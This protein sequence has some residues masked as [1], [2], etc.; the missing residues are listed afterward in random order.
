[1]NPEFY[2][3][4]TILVTG[5]T[6]LIGA[7]LIAEFLQHEICVRA[8]VHQKEPVIR[9]ER[10]EYVHGNLLNR[11]DCQRA[12]AGINFVFHCAGNSSGAAAQKSSP[13]SQV[14]DNVTLTS[15]LVEAACSA[16]VERF[17]LLSSTTLY[18]PSSMPVK[19][20]EA[21]V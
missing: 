20:E 16:H 6:G 15:Q 7:N 9:D 18:P 10:I 1:M 14:T 21:F 12:V 8:M 17:L 3:N 4:K 11:Q 2:R 13:F 5:S 19:E